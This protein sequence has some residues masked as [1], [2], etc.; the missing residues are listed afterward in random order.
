MPPEDE[1]LIGTLL[2]YVDKE[3]VYLA[4][5]T[6]AVA[7]KETFQVRHLR[8]RAAAFQTIP[9]SV[10]VEWDAAPKT[11]LFA[12]VVHDDMPVAH[13]DDYQGYFVLTQKVY[14]FVMGYMTRYEE[15]E[16]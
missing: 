15:L 9:G 3:K 13:D 6:Q 10:I 14:D 11:I 2:T 7:G 12:T 4:K 5:A 8:P 16:T 1:F